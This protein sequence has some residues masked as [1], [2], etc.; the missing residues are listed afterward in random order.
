MFEFFNTVFV[1]TYMRNF[2]YWL[3]M[4]NLGNVMSALLIMLFAFLVR[5]LFSFF[6]VRMLKFLVLKK[7]AYGQEKFIREISKPVAFI[8]IVI[9]L[10]FALNSIKLPVSI[11][12]YTRNML[13]SL[14]IYNITWLVYSFVNPIAFI[15][16]KTHLDN[17]QAVILTW[18]ARIAKFLIV[19]VG[20]SG[21]L[22]NWGVKVSTLIASLGIVGMAVALGAQDMFKNIISGVAII[23]EHRFSVGDIVK[24]DS[25][26]S[27]IEGV[28]ESIGFRSTTIRKF[29]RTLMFVPNSTLSDAAVVNFSSRMYRRIEWSISLGYQTTADQLR[30]ITREIKKYLYSNDDFVRPPESIS[31]VRL[32][33]FGAY[34][35]ELLIYCFTNTNVWAEWL[36]IKEEFILKIKEIVEKSG[37]GFAFPSSS[38]YVEKID[39]QVKTTDLPIKL[40]REMEKEF[41]TDNGLD[42]AVDGRNRVVENENK[43]IDALDGDV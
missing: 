22:E 32:D 17:T 11:A 26:D 4:S 33:R 3:K 18:V 10:Y 20:L 29:D 39:N 42:N 15:F 19:I 31:Q 12:Y 41:G 1:D 35:I 27:D 40:K 8:P 36:R 6:V 9:G 28:V 2:Y 16:R 43:R 38:I 24:L 25:S 34:S 30:Y 37:A 23:S 5:R 14:Y 21:L 7:I 13:K